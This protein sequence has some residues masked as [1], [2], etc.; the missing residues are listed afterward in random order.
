MSSCTGF[1][2][3]T[4]RINSNPNYIEDLALEYGFEEYSIIE[5]YY[6]HASSLYQFMDQPQGL[7]PDRPYILLMEWKENNLHMF[8]T[9]VCEEYDPVD[10]QVTMP[11]P[12]EMELIRDAITLELGYTITVP[13]NP[14]I[15][16]QYK[17]YSFSKSFE[18]Y[19]PFMYNLGSW[20]DGDVERTLYVFQIAEDTY[21]VNTITYLEDSGH[22]IDELMHFSKEDFLDDDTFNLCMANNDTECF[23][24]TKPY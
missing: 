1:Y 7:T 13:D 19:S 21:S 4:Q 16:D 23:V 12:E 20:Q 11:R 14:T 22:T 2:P 17:F 9:S 24:V 10:Y 8:F 5:T 15:M 6:S 18:Y 3:C